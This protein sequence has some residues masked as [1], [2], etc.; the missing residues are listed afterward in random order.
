MWYLALYLPFVIGDK[1]PEEHEMWHLCLKLREIM[2]VCFS[3][4]VSKDQLAYLQILIEDHHKE[5]CRIY[6]GCSIIP[7][8]HYGEVD[9]H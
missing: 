4:A 5:F 8:M 7:K 3:P 1:I 2:A 6:P 9:Y